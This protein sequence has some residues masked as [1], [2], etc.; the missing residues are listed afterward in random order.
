MHC[1]H[2]RGRNRCSN[3]F[4]IFFLTL[5]LHLCFWSCRGLM[6]LL[7]T[8][9]AEVL[10]V[11][12]RASLPGVRRKTP[13]QITEWAQRWAERGPIGSFLLTFQEKHSARMSIPSS[14]QVSSLSW[15]CVAGNLG[16]FRDTKVSFAVLQTDAYG[17]SR[18][19]ADR[20]TSEG[21]IRMSWTMAV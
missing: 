4:A 1:L 18:H 10:P 19:S 15:S 3:N 12:P 6:T 14:D 9:W 2:S 13:L 20:A 7:R 21:W 8:S 16:R 5:N 17:W 11:G